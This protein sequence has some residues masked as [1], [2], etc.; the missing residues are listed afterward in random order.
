MVETENLAKELISEF[1]EI[2][3]IKEAFELSKAEANFRVNAV[4]KSFWND[5]F[6]SFVYPLCPLY[7]IK[8]NWFRRVRDSKRFTEHKGHKGYTKDTKKDRCSP[9]YFDGSFPGSLR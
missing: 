6:V 8:T 4:S 1:R 2:Y 5:Y 3:H 7:S 9:N